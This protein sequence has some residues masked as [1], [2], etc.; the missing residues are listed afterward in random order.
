MQMRLR[1]TACT[2]VDI[3]QME[4][5]E[6]ELEAP[7]R[8]YTV[9]DLKQKNSRQHYERGGNLPPTLNESEMCSIVEAGG[10]RYVG[11]MNEIPGIVESVVLFTS[12]R[13][14]STLALPSSRLTVAAVRQQLA[15]SDAAFNQAGSK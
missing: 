14:R 13:T 5:Y 1:K 4:N 10:G 12:R 2:S 8:K 9:T 15:D 6:S 11:V 3:P 7:A